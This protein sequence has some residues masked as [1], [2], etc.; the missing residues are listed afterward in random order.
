MW[1]KVLVVAI[2]IALFG[3]VLK[4]IDIDATWVLLKQADWKLCFLSLAF[5]VLMTYLRGV[6]WSLLLKM[7]GYSY[8]VWN[9]FMVYMASM[10]WGNITPG[11]AGDFV[12][13][14]Y[15]KEDLKLPVGLGMANVLVDRVLDLYLLLVLGGLGILLNP[16]P[17]DPVSTHL[18]M[19]VKYLFVLLLV[20][21][22]LGFNKRIGGVLLK[23]AFQRLMKKEHREKT[24]RV[25][26]DFHEGVDSFYNPN[27]LL[28]VFFSAAAY[29][30]A[31]EGCYLLAQALNLPVS[32]FYLT[33][34]VSVVNIVSLLTFL[35]LG[36]R[37]VAIQK[38][39]GLISIAREPAEA[40]SFL[41]FLIG[42]VLFT[43]V[44]F[45]CSLLKPIQLK[46]K[47]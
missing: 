9:C 33:F 29:G 25:F 8:S 12:K 5:F 35:G 39:F 43:F 16:M 14:L 28:A 47:K 26:E 21:T 46:N 18:M 38:L 37:D 19:A 30:A 11:R 10:Y 41:L 6:R 40:Y 42:T 45:F 17:A 7:Q 23:A 20:M 44:C 3:F 24:D 1:K 27:F 15:L 2:G 4:S 36:T 13:I 34:T 31:F 32:F 22:L